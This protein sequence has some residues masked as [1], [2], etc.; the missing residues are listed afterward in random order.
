M[1]NYKIICTGNPNRAYTI[2]NSVK[3]F[4]PNT[5]FIHRSNGFDLT[6]D[7]GLELFSQQLVNYNVFL[8]CSYI[9]PGVQENLLNIVDKIWDQGRVFNIGSF[10]E[11]KTVHLDDQ[12]YIDSKK[13][14]KDRSLLLYSD[15]FK[16]TYITVDGYKIEGEIDSNKMPVDSIP[17]TIKW[18]LEETEFSV[19]FIGVLG[20]HTLNRC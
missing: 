11:F 8:N 2:A 12:D 7:T 14:F 3:K 19:P 17:R 10:V 1:K 6:T 16:T 15:K 20:N 5:T 9:A 4:F 13:K 18:I